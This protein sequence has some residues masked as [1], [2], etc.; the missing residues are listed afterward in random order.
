V[1]YLPHAKK[2]KP[3]KQP[4]LSNTRT[5]NGTVGLRNLFLVYGLVNTL[6]CRH[7]TS[8]FNSTG[9]ESFDLSLA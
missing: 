1:A 5:D 7:M 9:W 6:P 2:V 3:Q 4:F 8:H